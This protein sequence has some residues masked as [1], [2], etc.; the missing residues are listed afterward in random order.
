MQKLGSSDLSSVGHRLDNILGNIL[1]VPLQYLKGN[2]KLDKSACSHIELQTRSLQTR[3]LADQQRLDS[4]PVLTLCV[5]LCS[6]ENLIVASNTK[7]GK[8][9]SSYML[10]LVVTSSNEIEW[11]GLNIMDCG[12]SQWSADVPSAITY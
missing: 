4:T 1:V 7:S 2:V 12:Y 8:F 10:L 11:S 3:N 9:L 5:S 6:N